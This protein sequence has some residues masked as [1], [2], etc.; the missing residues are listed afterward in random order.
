MRCRRSLAPVK[1]LC[2]VTLPDPHAGGTEGNVNKAYTFLS[3]RDWAGRLSDVVKVPHRY[4]RRGETEKT[5]PQNAF[6]RHRLSEMPVDTS[7]AE[8]KASEVQTWQ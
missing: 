4:T 5:K 3:M 7:S 6:A 2:L 8:Q 1:S